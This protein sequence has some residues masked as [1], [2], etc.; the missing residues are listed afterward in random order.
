MKTNGSDLYANFLHKLRKK[1][2]SNKKR[3]RKCVSALGPTVVFGIRFCSLYFVRVYYVCHAFTFCRRQ[4]S[5][6]YT[7][8]AC[9]HCTKQIDTDTLTHIRTLYRTT[10]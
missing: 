1:N 9:A 5:I 4:L 6:P 3:N 10:W 2:A 7:M 8:V